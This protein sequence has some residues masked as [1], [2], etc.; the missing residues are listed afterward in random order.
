LRM[1]NS[2]VNGLLLGL[3]EG[4]EVPSIPQKPLK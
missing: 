3:L 4:A 1:P 2:F